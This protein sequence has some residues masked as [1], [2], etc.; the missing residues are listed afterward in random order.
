VTADDGPVLIDT[1]AAAEALRMEPAT[2]ERMAASRLLTPAPAD[3]N[4]TLWWHLHDLRRQLAAY[5]DEP[6]E[7]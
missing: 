1:D 6:S 3:D 5:L 7:D 2:L 4:G